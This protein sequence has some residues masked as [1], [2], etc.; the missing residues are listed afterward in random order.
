V[1]SIEGPDH[2]ESTEDTVVEEEVESRVGSQIFQYLTVFFL[3]LTVIYW[4]SSYEWA[5]TALLLLSGGLSAMTG[6]FLTLLDRRGGLRQELVPED[7][8]DR[9]VLFLPHASIRPFWVGSGAVLMAAGLPLGNWLL[10]P[11]AV[12]VGIGLVGMIEEGRRR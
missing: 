12:L 10:V 9:E 11:G 5:G 7:Y 1:T 3:V 2:V 4:F 8:E 6:G